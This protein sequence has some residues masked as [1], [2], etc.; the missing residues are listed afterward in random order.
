MS[1]I[2]WNDAINNGATIID[3]RNHY[4]SEIGKFKGAICPE[5]E[6]FKEELPLVKDLSKGNFCDRS[7]SL[8]YRWNSL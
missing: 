6:T 1:A 2:E 3:M 7:P 4:E 5:V 8:L